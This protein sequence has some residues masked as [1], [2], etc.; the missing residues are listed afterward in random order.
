MGTGVTYDDV[1]DVENVA[2]GVGD[3]DTDAV[4]VTTGV[5]VGT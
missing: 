4:D 1:I 5:D 2:D 3:S